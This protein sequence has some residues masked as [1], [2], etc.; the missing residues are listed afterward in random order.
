MPITHQAGNDFTSGSF[1]REP[2]WYHLVVADATDTPTKKGG[3]PIPNAMFGMD[4]KVCAG[5]SPGCEDKSIGLN[6]FHPTPDKEFTQKKIDRILIALGI[7][8]PGDEGKPVSFEAEDLIGRQFVT[9]LVHSQDPKYL[10]VNW[11]DTF[12][13]DDPEVANHPKNA[14]MLSIL[15]PE[16]RR[17]GKQ[18]AV[19]NKAN[20]PKPAP[21]KQAVQQPVAPQG[22]NDL[23]DI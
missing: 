11:S 17:V 4:C 8:Q 9:Q 19:T 12:H 2:G 15:P 6:F 7:M 21:A 18:G 3:V 5:T 20:P 14:D 10:E 13:V 16:Q 23:D 22:G 1:L